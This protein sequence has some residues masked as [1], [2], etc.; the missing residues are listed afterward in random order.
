MRL[1]SLRLSSL[2]FPPRIGTIVIAALGV[3]LFELL[4]LPLP[5]LLGTMFACLAAALAGAPLKGLGPISTAMRTILGVA[6]GASITPELMGRLGDFALSVALAAVFVML[7]GL[8]GYPYFRKLYGFDPP[9]AYYAAMPGGLQ[10]M[11]LFGH[12]AG[13]D[14]RALSLVHATRVLAIVSIMPFLLSGAWGLSLDKP[15]GLPAS[16]LPIL[17]LA[18]MAACALIGW[19]GGE[20]IG[21]FGA[22]I[23]G[24]MAVTAAASLA[25]LIHGR[26]PAEAILAAQ[27]FIGIAVGVHYVGV[28]AAELKR[29]V[30]AALGYCVM[31]AALALAFAEFVWMIGAAP[32][33]EAALAF[34]PGGQAEMVVLAIVAGADMAYVVTIHL[35]RVIIVILGAPI[36][37]RF[38]R[39]EKESGE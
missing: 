16:E 29:V 18:I 20:R 19:K 26:P 24:P 25:G 17:E 38:A 36:A 27:F 35:A 30:L 28:S 34:A 8:I 9:T 5:F 6:V 13:G 4:G 39:A 21:L 23:L 3:A 22:S 37:A 14:A 33:V 15:L 31:L 32:R 1:P 11:I 10:D 2:R 7:I 12:E